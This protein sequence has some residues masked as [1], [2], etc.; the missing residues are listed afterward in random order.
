MTLDMSSATVTMTQA[1]LIEYT[2]R[3]VRETTQKKESKREAM[4]TAL[5]PVYKALN[6]AFD[7]LAYDGHSYLWEHTDAEK[8]K[9]QRYRELRNTPSNGVMAA[10]EKIS[11]ARSAIRAHEKAQARFWK[12]WELDKE[13]KRRKIEKDTL[14]WKKHCDAHHRKAKKSEN[15]MDKEECLSMQIKLWARRSVLDAPPFTREQRRE[16]IAILAG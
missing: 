11:A 10:R 12:D 15:C 13:K 16:I 6:A 7:E 5:L 9:I 14:A 3:V 2:E 4:L 1:Q 8:A